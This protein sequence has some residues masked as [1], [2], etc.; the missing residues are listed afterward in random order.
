MSPP[1]PLVAV[2][3]VRAVRDHGDAV[4]HEFDMAEFLRRDRGDQAVE[5]PKLVLR[6]EVEALE[7]V[8]PE[9]G[10]LAVLAPEELLQGG[11]GVGIGPLGRRQVR[12]QL[13][14]AHEHGKGSLRVDRSWREPL[15][16][17]A[18]PRRF[19]V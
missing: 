18:V 14:D 5:R 13:V 3:L 2:R 15:A 12:L 9:G 6:A 1:S 17:G 7:H 19:L 11:G 10:H 8:V 4:G 16:V